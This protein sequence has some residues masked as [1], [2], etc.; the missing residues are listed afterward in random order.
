VFAVLVTVGLA[1]AA[2]DH[3]GLTAAEVLLP[4]GRAIGAFVHVGDLQDKEPAV[5]L[6]P[7]LAE[8]AFWS[9]GDTFERVLFYDCGPDARPVLT[10]DVLSCPDGARARLR[11]DVT[12]PDDTSAFANSNVPPVIPGG[13]PVAQSM[14][15]LAPLLPPAL[16]AAGLLILLGAWLSRRAR[17]LPFPPADPAPPVWTRRAVLTCAALTTLG[18]ILRLWGLGWE[19]FEQNE[20]TY[21]MS[22]M[23]HD[24][25]AGVL[26][27]V[28][29]M[30]QT[31]PPLYHLVLLAFRPLGNSELVARLPAA[32]AGAATIPLIFGLAWALFDGRLMPA[33]AAA[34]FA[35]LSPV[36]VWY[37][38]DVSPYT[39]TTLFAVIVLL[40]GRGILAD[41]S[42]RRPWWGLIIGSWGLVYTH[43]YGLHLTF[44]IFLLL[45]VRI[46]RRGP[47]WQALGQRTLA[48]GFFTWAGIAPWLPAFHQ[49]YQWSRGH[50]T[51]YQRLAQ[52]YHPA[53]DMLGDALDVLRLVAGYPVSLSLLALAGVALF[54]L[55]VPRLKLRHRWLLFAPVLWFVPFE[56]LNRATFLQSLYDGWYFGVRYFLFLFPV[57]WLLAGACLNTRDG[58]RWLKLATA[59]LAVVS[60]GLSGWET[61]ATLRA[62]NKPDIAGATR[63]VKEHLA[64]GDAVIV[65][66]A[67][68]YQH[69][70]HYYFADDDKRAGLRINDLMQTPAWHDLQQRGGPAWVGVLSE[71]FEPYAR[72][73]QNRHIKRVWVIDHTQHLFDRREFSDRASD[74]LTS[75]VSK[76]FK[77][78]WT[79]A[80]HDVSVRLFERARQ[81]TVTPPAELRFGWGDGP[82]IRRFRPPWAYASPGRRVIPGSRVLLPVAD[83]IQTLRLRAGTVPPG[84]HQLVDE[85]APVTIELA[86]HIDGEQVATVTLSQRFTEHTLPVPAGAADD[87]VLRLDFHLARPAQGSGR[88]PDAVLD[89]LSVD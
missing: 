37:S 49:A 74:A 59:A 36:H 57:A 62:D 10:S 70:F 55:H 56:I 83:N 51:A 4:D 34:A 1:C 77:P 21:F 79:R 25:P 38:Q 42:R 88:P 35:A 27:D 87:G 41:P 8:G 19:P 85:P 68:F 84:G 89:R 26:M 16:G 13:R 65:G 15:A 82:Y 78:V 45:G 28:N 50:S 73:L 63:L 46:L 39:F 29:A 3:P 60:L 33:A 31:H 32:L 52:V 72:S 69:P 43:Y 64:D 67:A 61:I 9:F 6:S 12:L 47:G 58:P 20:F 40:S 22:G 7:R 81:S 11:P 14:H 53:A 24:S 30:A 5:R 44:A 17:R 23:G 75:V 76:D 66:P 48:A 54:A 86:V 80:F 2:Q 18:L 71:L